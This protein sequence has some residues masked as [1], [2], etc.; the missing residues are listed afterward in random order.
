MT[1][2]RYPGILALRRKTQLDCIVCLCCLLHKCGHIVQQ[3]TWIHNVN[4]CSVVARYN[5]ITIINLQK[6]ISVGGHGSWNETVEHPPHAE[7]TPPTRVYLSAA[8]PHP[9]GQLYPPCGV[10]R[11]CFFCGGVVCF[12]YS[13]PMQSKTPSYAFRPRYFNR[14][15]KNIINLY[16]IAV[17]CKKYLVLVVR[18]MKTSCYQANWPCCTWPKKLSSVQDKSLKTKPAIMN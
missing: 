6:L 17:I 13:F 11:V 8:H 9:H 15:C 10:C 16:S 5:T 12:C 18:T 3:H 1:S 14:I 7:V 4:M 2:M